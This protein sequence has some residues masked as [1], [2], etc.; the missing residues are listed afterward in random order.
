ME[1]HPCAAFIG[2]T[3]PLLIAVALEAAVEYNVL[4]ADTL[5][6]FLDAWLPFAAAQQEKDVRHRRSQHP[7]SPYRQCCGI[8]CKSVIPL[9]YL[10]V[11][12][13]EAEVDRVALTKE[14]RWEARTDNDSNTAALMRPYAQAEGEGAG[15][16]EAHKARVQQLLTSISTVLA[17]N[18]QRLVV[19]QTKT[20]GHAQRLFNDKLHFVCLPQLSVVE[21]AMLL[22]SVHSVRCRFQPINDITLYKRSHVQEKQLRTKDATHNVKP[23]WVDL[24]TPFDPSVLWKLGGA[25]TSEQYTFGGAM[26]V[27]STSSQRRT[28]VPQVRALVE[29]TRYFTVIVKSW[30]PMLMRAL[31]RPAITATVN[32]AAV[33]KEGLGEGSL[34]MQSRCREVQLLL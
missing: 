26:N 2:V 21:M 31:E 29:H 3:A 5:A 32:T 6:L 23:T 7:M 17:H 9:A 14:G 11:R 30:R 8:S 15:V 18:T 24:A 4:L 1:H 25:W 19:Q 16:T 33:S 28:D 10:A 27:S 22:H 13:M 12:W 20:T 34:I